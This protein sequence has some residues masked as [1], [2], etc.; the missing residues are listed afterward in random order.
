MDPYYFY[1]G[2]SDKWFEKFL[3]DNGFKIV[4]IT[5]VGDYYS[6]LSVEIKR[7]AA[8]HSIWAK[9][10]LAPAFFYFYGKKKTRMSVDTLCMGYHVVAI[11]Q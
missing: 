3:S 6:W 11:K 8:T 10:L 1:S 4:C 2:F 5:P 7:T 9:V